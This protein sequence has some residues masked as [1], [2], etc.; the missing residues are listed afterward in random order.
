MRSVSAPPNK[1]IR[2]LGFVVAA[3]DFDAD[4][5]EPTRCALFILGND[6]GISSSTP[7]ASV[8]VSSP[9]SSEAG[10]ESTVN[11]R[12]G[13]G[14]VGVDSGKNEAGEGSQPRR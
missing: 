3:E 4:A 2:V 5:D 1:L 6:G 8:S 14:G 10:G 7:S 11:S 12:D 9:S 13:T